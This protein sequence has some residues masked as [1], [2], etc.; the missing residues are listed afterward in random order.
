MRVPIRF[1]AACL[2]LIACGGV[3]LHD[4]SAPPAPTVVFL[5]RHAEPVYP[6]PPDE[7]RNPPLNEVGRARAEQ[8][9][10]V[11]QD[12]GIT[13][14]AS[15]ELHRTQQT[16]APLAERLGLAVEPYDPNDLAGLAARL[17][18]EPGRVLVSG[19]SN[20]TP[21]LVRLLGG[22]PGE[23]IDEKTEFDR[24][25]VVVLAPGRPPET[26]L[27]HYGAPPQPWPPPWLE[28]EAGR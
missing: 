24:L 17:R 12:A 11:L 4:S 1:A 10:H 8:L 26:T 5:V 13:R 20:T 19:H 28:D 14:I 22:D 27:L 21:E 9:A 7:P 3:E 25:Y 23:P 2:A 16:A 18:A 15:T 6:P